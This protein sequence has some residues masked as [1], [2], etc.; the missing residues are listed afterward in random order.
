M[1]PKD[2]QAEDKLKGKKWRLNHVRCGNAL[3]NIAAVV[4]LNNA[5][6]TVTM[7][8]APDGTLL[9]G[10]P[11]GVTSA[12]VIPAH[13]IH[14]DEDWSLAGGC[15]IDADTATNALNG[16]LNNNNYIV[17][18][19]INISQIIYWFK[20]NYPTV[21]REQQKLIFGTLT[22]AQIS[23]REKRIQFIRSLSPE[24]KVDLKRLGL[25][26]PL[27]DEL[28]ET[29]E[30]I[31]TERNNLFLDEDIY[32]QPATKTKPKTSS[33]QGIT[34][35]D[36]D[37]ITISWRNK[38]L[39]NSKKL[40]RK[41]AE[42]LAI[43]CF[44]S[45]L[46]RTKSNKQPEDEYNYDPVDDITD[47]IASMTLNK[48]TIILSNPLL[49]VLLR[50]VPSVLREIP[51]EETIR[52]VLHSELKLIFPTFFPRFWSHCVQTDSGGEDSISK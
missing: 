24:N 20:R 18:P 31:E 11:T 23:D 29:L 50:N 15:P 48:A 3:A 32:N 47:S 30:E 51:L 26:R 12:T 40:V 41:K 21:V 5:N 19:D 34:I 36:V 17:L 35:E 45:N 38:T 2:S 39:D 44:L 28:I 46:L 8:N 37:R 43:R 52:K 1:L 27:N 14:V 4:V 7:I 33:H 10:L 49:G 25:N 6:I 42:D 16:A 13:N 22:Q 9:P